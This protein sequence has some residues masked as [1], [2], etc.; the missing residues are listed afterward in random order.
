MHRIA[1]PERFLDCVHCG[2]C[3]QACPTYMELG[4]EMDSPRGRIYLMRGVQEGT[5]ELTSDVVRH[6]D[7]CLGCRACETACPSGVR[8]GELIEGARVAVEAARRRSFRE[9]LRRRIVTALFPHP[10][11]LR[12][13]LWPLR[14]LD[15]AGV[16]PVLRRHVAVAGLLPR[17]GDWSPLA[18]ETLPRGAVKGRVA[19][20]AGCV[21]QVLGAETNRATVRVLTRNGFAVA[22]PRGQVCCGALRLHAGD[23]RAALACAR[24]NI[25]AFP[26]DVRAVVV[27]AAGCG[28]MLK[29]YG[30]LLAD[31][32][33]YGARARA[34]SARV[35]DVTEFLAEVPLAV[36]L[37]RVGLRVAY[38]DACHLA[39]GQGVRGAP[40]ALLA[41]IPGVELVEL[42]DSDVCC[43]SA[44]SYSLMEPDMARRL[45]A[46]KAESV[47][48]TGVA[49]VAAA[50][51]GCVIQI[52]AALRRAG[53]AVEVRHPIELLD[54]AYGRD[55]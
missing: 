33:L 12:L 29:Q 37:G 54:E 30:E 47:R 7:L 28:A 11:R 48:A 17:L 25:D 5:L 22:T 45:G 18:E 55:G 43:G 35:R 6:V 24:Q 19:F 14:W 39:H 41:A 31:D 40:R 27:N 4:T 26:E 21:G 38:H 49:C 46:R 16:L 34:F 32:V 3:M 44:G 10:A 9:R 2:L 13:A 36:P 53:M 8:Y 23:R 20:L 15:R 42:P 52:R 50:N 51:V 1:A